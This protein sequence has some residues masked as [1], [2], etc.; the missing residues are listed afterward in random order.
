MNALDALEAQ[1]RANLDNQD[2]SYYASSYSSWLNFGTSI[3]TNILENLQVSTISKSV[4]PV[5]EV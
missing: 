3:V 2:Q 1:W 4:L 5:L